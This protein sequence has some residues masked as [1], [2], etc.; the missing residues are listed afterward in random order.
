MARP[1]IWS[2]ESLINIE[3]IAEY[4]ARDSL[5]YSR[6][7]ANQIFTAGESLHE[8]PKRGSMVVELGNP[9]I[10]ELFIYDYRLIYEE[11][12]NQT[13]ILAVIHG[14]RLLETV[15]QFKRDEN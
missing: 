15:A 6:I 5:Y 1:V 8:N 13:E 12:N 14:R 11:K 7:V 9:N 4:I 3:R 10:K 2:E